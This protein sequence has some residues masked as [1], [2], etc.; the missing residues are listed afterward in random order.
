MKKRIP[1]ALRKLLDNLYIENP[2]LFE[3]VFDDNSITL[4]D[5]DTDSNYSFIIETIEPNQSKVYAVSYNPS[6]VFQNKGIRTSG[7]LEAI[8]KH[9][10]TWIELLIQSNVKSPIFDDPFIQQYYDELEPDFKIL[11]KDANIKP[12]LREEQEK[13]IHILDNS[14]KTILELNEN[15]KDTKE[16]IKIIDETKNTITIS[17]KAQ[18][19]K[20]IKKIIAI[21]TKIGLK[22]GKEL[23]IDFTTE[24]TKK[25]LLG[26]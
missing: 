20:R 10:N 1:I 19:V 3:V 9:M 7:T 16:I 11:D 23:F 12:Y 18:V 21:A 24:L 2:N 8:K 4:K 13:I 5:I 6:T 15:N 22:V 17:T 14:K 25:L 26:F